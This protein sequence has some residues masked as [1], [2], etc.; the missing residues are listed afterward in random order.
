M[1]AMY[2]AHAAAPHDPPVA[3]ARTSAR[4]IVPSAG[5]ET[6]AMGRS[7][8]PGPGGRS[9]LLRV[10]PDR[11]RCPVSEAE[12]SWLCARG[13][14]HEVLPGIVCRGPVD[15]AVRARALGLVLGPG[16]RRATLVHRH[17]AAWI[18][19]CAPMPEEIQLAAYTGTR[20]HLPEAERHLAVLRTG[21][22]TAYDVVDTGP[23]RI[24]TALRTCVDLALLE[25]DDARTLSALRSLLCCPE[26]AVHPD[27]VV[28]ALRAIPRVVGRARAEARVREAASW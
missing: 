21:R 18:R 6:D 23:V 20:P 13:L 25:E 1:G 4:A 3:S 27:A 15:P 17:T 14:L 5:T 10:G 11:T 19:G 2:L 7:G 28:I 22:Y 16:T 12:A 24:T 8:P 9:E 26:T